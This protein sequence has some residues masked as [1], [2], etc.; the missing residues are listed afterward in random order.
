ME[1]TELLPLAP[2]LRP[3]VLPGVA[4]K[5]ALGASV[6]K[7]GRELLVSFEGET[8]RMH[9]SDFDTAARVAR[10]LK[11]TFPRNRNASAILAAVTKAEKFTAEEMFRPNARRVLYFP[12]L[13]KASAFY[14]CILP[15]LATARG[16]R[17]TAHVTRH[18]NVREAFDYEIVVI[19]I[20]HA[21]A[22]HRFAH[23]LK[24]MGKKIVFEIDDAFDA[25]EPWH[26]CYELY[27]RAEEQERVKAMLT[28]A[29][30]VTVTTENLRERYR[31][32]A[33][34]I[35]VIP[36]F[37]PLG[38][39]PQAEPHGTDEFRVLWAGSPSHFGDLAT[40][41]QALVRFA[42]RH[43]NVRL[44]FFGKEPSSLGVDKAQVRHLAY[45]DFENYPVALAD[46][47]ADMAIAP[48]ADIP[49]NH[50]KSNIKIL[51]YTATGYPVVAS[52]VG[53]Y[54]AT[55]RH[56]ET[57]ILCRTETEWEAALE[58]L[59]S[60]PAFRA[61]LANAGRTIA[62]EYDIERNAS[63]IEDFFVSF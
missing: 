25:L 19:Q 14:R 63:A 60:D 59:R 33:K 43:L 48:L 62:R 58:S 50:A 31:G 10:R 45:C 57:G 35:D 20:D 40:V 9:E 24:S 51:E 36:N 12:A 28:L 49:F 53:P 47:R 56:G 2:S 22:T 29:D 38:D 44:M 3:L 1:D 5:L 54:R 41:G 4:V 27:S 6:A 15:A 26:S 37:I 39:W 17:V 61:R 55:I 34:R 42:S 16:T 23:V 46:L 11:A 30:A 8:L 32:R 52:D 13:A 21:P 7:R 18:R